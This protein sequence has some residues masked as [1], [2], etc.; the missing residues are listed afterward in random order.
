MLP[1]RE[2][3]QM[4]EDQPVVDQLDVWLFTVGQCWDRQPKEARVYWSHPEKEHRGE[5]QTSSCAKL[6]FSPSTHG[7]NAD[8]TKRTNTCDI[9][10]S[11]TSK[12]N[13]GGLYKEPQYWTI[14]MLSNCLTGTQK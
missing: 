14:R 5:T 9:R 11:K 3:N 12:V 13:I 10:F 2:M 1:D 4:T 7:V 8:F 6:L